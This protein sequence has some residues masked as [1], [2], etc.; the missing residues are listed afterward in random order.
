MP[1]LGFGLGMVLAMVAAVLQFDGW[2]G[3]IAVG[4]V[5]GAG[6]VVEGFYLTPRLVGERIG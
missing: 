6:Q 2:Y 3:M 5:Y 1:Y 4:A